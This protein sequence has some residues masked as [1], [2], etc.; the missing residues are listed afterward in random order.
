MHF[1][2]NYAPTFVAGFGALT[3]AF[4]AFRN[5]ERETKPAL[6][7]NKPKTRT[8]ARLVL[9]GA[10]LAMVGTLWSGLNQQRSSER[11][12]GLQTT[13][14]DNT[15][16]IAKL[17][18][19]LAV[20]S[21]AVAVLAQRL[22]A[23]SDEAAVMARKLGQKS[24]RIANVTTEL[25]AKDGEIAS[26]TK[27]LAVKSDE[28]A[29]MSQKLA[30]KSEENSQTR[31]EDLETRDMTQE[32]LLRLIAQGCIKDPALQKEIDAVH[33]TFHRTAE[34]TLRSTTSVT[35]TK[36]PAKPPAPPKP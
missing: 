35:V 4:G 24:D 15:N 8:Q 11:Q 2:L 14:I 17:N 7:G 10:M 29:T 25:A 32:K 26:V 27:R 36:S 28:L 16:K 34:E 19:N 3:S 31:K 23:R 18:E 30:A 6:A 1:V 12:Q 22:A 20:K 21:D 9:C 33:N 13:L 5:P